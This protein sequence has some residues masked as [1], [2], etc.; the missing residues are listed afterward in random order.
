MQSG[1][2]QFLLCNK[3]GLKFSQKG[4]LKFHIRH[5]CGRIHICICGVKCRRKRTM[6]QH[7]RSK[8]PDKIH[9][10][11]TMYDVVNVVS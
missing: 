8:H 9:L 11:D 5:E 2:N 3:C 7:M 6:M 4:S 10:H 1:S